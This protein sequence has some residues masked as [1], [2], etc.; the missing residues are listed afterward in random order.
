MIYHPFQYTDKHIVLLTYIKDIS[1]RYSPLVYKA[2]KKVL[3]RKLSGSKMASVS[4]GV[5]AWLL[6]LRNVW[7]MFVPSALR[8]VSANKG[9]SWLGGEGPKN[10]VKSGCCWFM[11]FDYLTTYSKLFTTFLLIYILQVFDFETWD[12]T[13]NNCHLGTAGQK[14]SQI[15]H[16][17]YVNSF[18]VLE[19]VWIWK[20]LRWLQQ[21]IDR[22][23]EAEVTTVSVEV[24]LTFQ[25]LSVSLPWFLFSAGN[26]WW[27]CRFRTYWE[28]LDLLTR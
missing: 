19:M 28:S 17:C 18:L 10:S 15:M 20:R 21:L 14:K 24:I 22:H 4:V 12:Y 23:V 8:N 11:I 26:P 7:E 2:H 27:C 3:T 9:T 1:K 16:K 6:S 25:T 13:W 5:D